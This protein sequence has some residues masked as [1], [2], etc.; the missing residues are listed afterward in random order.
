MFWVI[1]LELLSL[2]MTHSGQLPEYSR[3]YDPGRDA[4]SDGKAALALAAKSGRKVLIEVGGDW[5]T[6]CHVLER[7][8]HENPELER[9]L[10]QHY[11]LLKVNVS[12]GN[13]NNDF[14]RDMPILHGYPQL[15][16]AR[17]NGDIV[18]AQDPSE[19][20]VHGSYDP[21]LILAFLKRWAGKGENGD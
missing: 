21:E 11:V 13:D 4:F 14:M 1:L 17:R 5:C 16:V 7:V 9:M 10:R 2:G 15:F 20:I 19:F 6:W 18:H 3:V 8:I 12:E